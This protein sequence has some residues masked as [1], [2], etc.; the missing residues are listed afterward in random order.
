MADKRTDPARLPPLGRGLLFLAHPRTPGVALALLAVL[1]AGLMAAD[2][3]YEKH[4]YVKLE[5]LFGF[6]GWFACA[7]GVLCLSVARIL[8]GVLKRP[9]GYFGQR[10]T[11]TE[12][13]PADQLEKKTIHD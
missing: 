11:A 7:G 1:G 5:Y 3:F 2:L 6:Y 9:E 4:P 13:M 12:E 10:D 8:Q